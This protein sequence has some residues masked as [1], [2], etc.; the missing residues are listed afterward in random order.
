M[1]ISLWQVVGPVLEFIVLSWTALRA[2]IKAPLRLRI[3]CVIVSLQVG[4]PLL[5]QERALFTVYA[6]KYEGRATANGE[7]FSHAKMTAAANKQQYLGKTVT[8]CYSRCVSVWV[9]DV[10]GPEIRRDKRTRFDLTKAAAISM[11]VNGKG[12]GTVSE[13]AALGGDSLVTDM[14]REGAVSSHPRA[15]SPFGDRTNEA[16]GKPKETIGT[17]FD[18]L[19]WRCAEKLGRT[20]QGDQ[21]S[22]MAAC[23]AFINVAR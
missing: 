22:L 10:F 14:A 3:L 1:L 15:E 11:G 9:N 2:I 17:W 8:L 7:M 6:P 21:R 16:N 19:A 13:G 18:T 20:K 23:S 4:S 12:W 5:A